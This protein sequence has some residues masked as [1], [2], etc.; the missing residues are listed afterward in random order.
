MEKVNIKRMMESVIN[1]LSNNETIQTYALKIKF[2]ANHLKNEKFTRWVNNE[3][4]GYRNVD[5]LP[6]YRLLN[7]QIIAD[8]LIDNGIKVLTLKNSEMPLANLGDKELIKKLSTI[9]LRESVISLAS[10]LLSKQS[11]G[12]TVTEYERYHLSNIYENSTIL[13]AHKRLTSL[14]CENVIFKFKARLLE[15]FMEFNDTIFNDEL[16]FDIMNKKKEVDRIVSHTINAGVYMENSSAKI[17]NT[18]ITVGD[19]NTISISS[20]DK[21][22]LNKILGEIEKIN[23][24]TGVNNQEIKDEILNIRNEIEQKNQKPK[25]VKSSLNAIKGIAYSIAA[26]QILQLANQGLEIVGRFFS[27]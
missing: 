25:L 15:M 1:D 3:L 19:N 20:H 27:S 10:M 12:Y 16:D 17:D 11:L 24:S 22:M 14:D 23:E 2:I 26:N 4:E 21:E 5:E 7:T 18:Q 8:L 6:S 9:P 13:S